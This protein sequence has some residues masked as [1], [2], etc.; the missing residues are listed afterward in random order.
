MLTNKRPNLIPPPQP[1]LPRGPT[2]TTLINSLESVQN[3]WS[4]LNT[5]ANEHQGEQVFLQA[6][7]VRILLLKQ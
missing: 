3:R 5:Y 6:G 2:T 7:D 1:E 4:L